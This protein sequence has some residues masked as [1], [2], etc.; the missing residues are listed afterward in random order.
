MDS[1]SQTD[2][3]LIRCLQDNPRAS[4]AQ[5]SRITGI[6]ETT[7]RRKI[8]ALIESQV[9]TPSIQPNL[10]L[11]G[12]QTSAMVGLKTEL[13]QM[14]AIARK[15]RDFP[16]VTFVGL[17]TGRFD[18]MFFVA[19]S[20]LAAL[21]EFMVQRIAPIDGIKQT[22]TLVTPRVLKVL[23][24]WRVP[25]EQQIADTSESSSTERAADDA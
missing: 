12:Y 13:D 3:R 16:E 14:D 9:I 24:D 23:G 7:T 6:S 4:Y 19:Q 5:I 22:E 17:T 20:S 15:I 18:V 1:V 11:L 8:D 2:L 21:T 10:H 25:V